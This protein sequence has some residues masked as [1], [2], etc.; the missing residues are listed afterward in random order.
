MN[1]T[2]TRGLDPGDTTTFE[3]P[4]PEGAVL[5]EGRLLGFATSHRESHNH[6]PGETPG[7]GRPCSAC[8]WV[9]IRILRDTDDT[10]VV[11]T[12]G[13]SVLEGETTRSRV[14]FT[15]SAFEILEVLTDRRNHT[16]R[17]P[18]VAAR[19][20]AIAAANDDDIRD[21]YINRAVV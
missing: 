7:G 3:L 16:T 19:A 13:H 2:E 9:E 11:S 1:V 15:D 6:F 14:I 12:V 21:A 8:R 17:L 20:V 10:Y 4:T 18:N 5:V